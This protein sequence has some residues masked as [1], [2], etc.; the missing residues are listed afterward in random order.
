MST[1]EQLLGQTEAR[2]AAREP[3]RAEQMNKIR[4]GRILDADTPERVSR[5][6]DRL[7]VDRATAETLLQPGIS[8][9][10][11]A[12]AAP[13]DQDRV[14][15]ERILGESDLMNVNFLEFG[16]RACRAIGRVHIRNPIG[17]VVGY[18]TGF[19][20][21]P[22]LLL[23]NNHVLSSLQEASTSQVEFNYQIGLDGKL[24][25]SIFFGLAPAEFMLTDEHLDY[26]LVAVQQAASD[27]TELRAFGWIRL[28]EEQGKIVNG[29][30]MNIIQHPGGEPKQ[31]AL[32]AN[33]LIDIL[34]D[35]LHYQTDTAPG[36]SGA[37]VGNDEWEVVALHHAG[38][39]R[40]DAQGHILTPDGQ[41]WR[42][43]M[44]EHRIDWIANEG[45]RISRI[46]GHVKQQS[47]SPTQQRLLDEMLN[48][49]IEV[50][51]VA[52]PTPG[53][54]P[55]AHPIELGGAAPAITAGG[56][57]TWT[58][59][60]SITVGIGLPPVL[61]P[62]PQTGP[63]A[64][65]PAG[66]QVPPD[67]E[68]LDA[69]RELEAASTRV[70]YDEAADAAARE[71]YYEGI[72]TRLN[73][74]NFYRRLSTLVRTTHSQQP[75]YKPSRH[76]YPWV[77]LHPDL[78]L[79]SIYSGR[80]ADPEE[81][82]REDLRT[83]HERARRVQQLLAT[84]AAASAEWLE[85]QMES[86][87]AFLPYNCEHVVPQSWF[88]KREPMRG[89]LHHLFACEW[90]CNSFRGNKAYFDFADFEEV[91]RD[92]CGKR[93]DPNR[94]EPA[95]GK[96]AVARATLYFLLRYPGEVAGDAQEF[97]TE[98]LPVLLAWHEADPVDEYERHRNAAIFEKQ[99][100][101]NPLIDFPE[102]AEKIDFTLGFG[103]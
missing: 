33:Q 77:D 42:T 60:L 95:S 64:R 41:R 43:H 66:P 18:G 87:E 81:Y 78:K 55:A 75:R 76:V 7:G 67:A 98:R 36:S 85:A 48:P 61:A 6:L 73:R 49:Q 102:W 51:V 94:F 22:R 5:R 30:R 27:G 9:A 69:L 62:A 32:R 47:L 15:L 54:G 53:A 44:G 97:A 50:P 11:V 103:E 34:D 4:A 101:R 2:F 84:E 91:V 74:K 96:G 20:V 80:L 59:P 83:S 35:F 82:I 90:G 26:T 25:P 40:R 1:F 70:Y 28:I 3:Q 29:E 8:F 93:V 23:T 19:L 92:A 72:S 86:L 52:G 13:S 99:G 100:N 45:V 63:A 58:I 71:A 17:Q 88:D 21:S 24:T 37:W 10:P 79:R 56:Q 68:L 14:L 31:L 57:A 16:T 38:V 12:A 89:D 65:P 39:P 46:V